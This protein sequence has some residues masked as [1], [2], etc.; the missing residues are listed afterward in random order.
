MK[1]ILDEC[2]AGPV[3]DERAEQLTQG[4]IGWQDSGRLTDPTLRE[5]L[6]PPSFDFVFS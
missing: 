5:C 6:K 3:T 2:G 4:L 1:N